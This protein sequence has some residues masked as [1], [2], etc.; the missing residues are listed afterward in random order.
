DFA[1]TARGTE[2]AFPLPIPARP[3]DPAGVFELSRIAAPLPT[4]LPS[5]NQIGFD[6]I[7]YLITLVESSQPGK[8]IA[9]VA[10]AKL[11][12]AENRTAIDPA[13]RVLFAV[14]A[15]FDGGLLTLENQAG[16]TIEFNGIRLPF[17]FF[18]VATRLDASG[19]ALASPALN[20]LAPCA[21]ISFYGPFLRELGFCNPQTDILDVFGG[22]ELHRFG[23]G[24]AT[25]PAGVGSVSFAATHDSVRATL[26]GSSLRL[27]DHLV[28]ILLVDA[29]GGRPVSLDYGFITQRSAGPA[30]AL[31][32]V[33]VPFGD[34]P[35]PASVRAWLMVDDAPVAVAT[36][37][38]P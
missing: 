11:A 22:A 4:I 2:T 29:D 10:G 18:R 19:D 20:V 36:L 16:F 23:S 8:A 13:S 38:I 26:D 31:L 28:S 24:V 37:Q 14:D 12:D 6:S 21:G 25:P 27:A 3:G 32:S 30:G 7:H 35:V 15:S 34:H 9:W 1:V 33:E 5:Y 17:D